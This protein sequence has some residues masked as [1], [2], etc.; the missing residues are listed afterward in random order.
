MG[1]LLPLR[2]PRTL[3]G[4]EFDEWVRLMERRIRRLNRA[5]ILV[6]IAGFAGVVV[7]GLLIAARLI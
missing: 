2:P 1:Q 6:M 7:L 4:P 5:R 3:H